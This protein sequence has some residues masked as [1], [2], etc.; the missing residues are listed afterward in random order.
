MSIYL[1]GSMAYDRIMNFPGKFTD[2]ILADQIHNL[3][4][5]FFIDSL[6]EQL[7]GNAGNIAYTL[8][9]LSEPSIIVASAG[10]DFD[11]YASVLEARGLSL[12]GIMR[13][14]DELCASAYIMTD[15]S[16][17]QITGFHAAAMMTPSTYDFP[18]LVPEDD[19]AL[20]GPSNPDD[21]KRH[22]ALYREKGVRYIYDPSQQLPILSATDLRAAID[23]AYL[24]VGN[25]YEI[26]LIMNTTGLSKEELVNMTT[27]G[28]I[29]TLGENGSLVTEKDADAELEIKAVAIAS[30]LDPTGAGDAY[31]AG[32]IKGLLLK[33]SLAECARLGSTCAAFCIEQKGTQGHDFS[34][35]E[36]FRRHS[37]AF[38][39]SV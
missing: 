3:N 23:G 17:N 27:R 19:I 34:I 4:V 31:R 25:D 7:G 28:I 32:L 26:R 13:L 39:N 22:P 2:S 15:Q 11:R 24:L 1:T 38:G 10:R 12:E 21:M 18:N 14:E 36:F 30:V 5:S 6:D 9:L 16:N 8:S 35:E 29:T 20:I 37:A 33:Q